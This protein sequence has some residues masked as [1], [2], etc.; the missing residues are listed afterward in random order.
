MP[1]PIITPSCT[2]THPTGV[3]S[4]ASASSAC[5]YQVRKS[6]ES[7]KAGAHVLETY[8][9]DGFTHEAFMLFDVL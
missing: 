3:S 4:L 8:H 6:K 9:F 5:K 2:K 7:K 1:L